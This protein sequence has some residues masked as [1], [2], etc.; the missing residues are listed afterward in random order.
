MGERKKWRKL[1]GVQID[2]CGDSNVLKLK[3]ENNNLKI[4]DFRGFPCGT[5]GQGF[6]VIT[7]V[8]W[9]TAVV[10]V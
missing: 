9:V 3:V 10:W 8:A 7:A 4:N 1:P 6:C 5:V 2:V